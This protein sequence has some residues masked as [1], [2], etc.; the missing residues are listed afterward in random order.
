MK[1]IGIDY[2]GKRTGISLSDE[3]GK[4]AFPHSVAPTNKFFEILKEL[5]EK[6][7]VKTIVIGDSKD[8]KMEDND[9]MKEVN[10][11]VKK[12]KEDGGIHIE[13]Y[14]EFMTSQ[15]AR[16]VAADDDMHDARAAALI[17]QGYLDSKK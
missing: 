4:F 14:P 11:F 9:I 3:R 16:R 6:E 8:F 15:M 10:N 1:Y 5:V 7:D 17:L 2:G 13:M 12:W